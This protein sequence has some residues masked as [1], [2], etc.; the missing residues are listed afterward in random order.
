MNTLA[1]WAS[2]CSTVIKSTIQVKK[3]KNSYNYSSQYTWKFNCYCSSTDWLQALGFRPLIGSIIARGIN[4]MTPSLSGTHALND[5]KL[6]PLSKL[7]SPKE[8]YQHL[9][10]GSENFTRQSKTITPRRMLSSAFSW[11]DFGEV[12]REEVEGKE[13]KSQSNYCDPEEIWKLSQ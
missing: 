3:L 8:Q 11:W 6:P 2:S 12:R 13:K 1:Q 4:S 10:K 5:Q 9:E 7:T